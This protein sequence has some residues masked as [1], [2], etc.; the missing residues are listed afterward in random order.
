MTRPVHNLLGVALALVLFAVVPVQGQTYTDL[1][2]FTQSTGSAPVSP[3]LLAQGQ[4]GNIY[5]SMPTGGSGPPWAGTVFVYPLGGI[6]Q[7]LY[8][9]SGPDGFGPASG[10][11]LGFDGNFYGTTYLPSGSIYGEVYKITPAGALTVL[12][13]F[14]NGQNDGGYPYTAPIQAPDGNL[15]GV[16]YNGSYPGVAYR[17]TPSGTFTYLNTVPSA[18]AAP[19]ILGVDGKLYGTTPYGGTYNA[20]TVFQLT[21]KGKLKIVYSFN[22]SG[23]IPSG[24]VMQGKD[25][26]LYGTTTWG[27]TAGQGVVYQVSTAGKYA[28]LHN[29]TG[30]DG[31][32]SSAGVVQ[33]SDGFLYGVTPGGGAH[34]YG[35]FFKISTKG[36]SFAV[37]HDFD[38]KISG[39]YPFSTPMLHTNGLIYGTANTGPN[40][41]ALYS[42]N[43]G[44]KPFAS[45]FVI[46][47]GK[48]GTSVGILGQG[49]STA[50]GVKFGTGPGT[51]TVVSDTYMIATVAAGATTG[52]VTVL[53]PG[54]NLVTPQTFKVLP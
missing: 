40:E 14:S 47:S 7:D 11:S 15:Y 4:D 10:L 9:F 12:H 52:P 32:N 53:E 51:F 22:A 26:K 42:M 20:G 35:T 33:G 13:Q 1:F 48:V 6:V 49:F 29:F 3:G 5:S 43:V 36:K 41:G 44:L 37:L 31:S 23:T 50:T 38:G 34:G 45:L 8:F 19:L 39:G 54:G 17:I 18:T 30:T 21:T 27:G 2:D 25:K 46:W 16:T 28:V 24:P